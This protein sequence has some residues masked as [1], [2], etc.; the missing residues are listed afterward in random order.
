MTIKV[1]FCFL[2]DPLRWLNFRI[3]MFACEKRS[4]NKN[5]NAECVE[6]G[7]LFYRRDFRFPGNTHRESY[8]SLTRGPRFV[9]IPTKDILT[10]FDYHKGWWLSITSLMKVGWLKPISSCLVQNTPFGINWLIWHPRQQSIFVIKA[11]DNWR[12]LEHCW[13]WA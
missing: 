9:C 6:C 10:A 5:K 12:L 8:H 2:R 13:L 7:V 1:K 4:N 11:G 3:P